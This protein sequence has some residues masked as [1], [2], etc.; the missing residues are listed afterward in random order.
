MV[1]TYIEPSYYSAAISAHIHRPGTYALAEHVKAHESLFQSK[2][3]LE[4]GSATGYEHRVY[5][6]GSNK[7]IHFFSALLE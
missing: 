4:L 3:I 7:L 6:E 2:T 1:I 5:I